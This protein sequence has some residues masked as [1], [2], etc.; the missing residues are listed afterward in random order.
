MYYKCI[1]ISIY[2]RGNDQNTCMK[3]SQVVFRRYSCT[4]K[5]ILG[6]LTVVF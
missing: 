6:I 2:K 3:F 5:A 1:S 4:N